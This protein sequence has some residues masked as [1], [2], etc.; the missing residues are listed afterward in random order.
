MYCWDRTLGTIFALILSATLAL[1]TIHYGL[2]KDNPYCPIA[3]LIVTSFMTGILTGV[4]CREKRQLYALL[5]ALLFP[6]LIPIR[7]FFYL[8]V[9]SMGRGF[10]CPSLIAIILCP[11]IAC[12][13]AKVWERSILPSK[14]APG[15]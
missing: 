2:D 8:L 11:I 10:I 12:A 7:M 9:E 13:G 6:L 4:I 3:A 1:T 15:D 5:I 14:Q